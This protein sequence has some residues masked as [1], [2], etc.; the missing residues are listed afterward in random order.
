MD[1][2]KIE[3]GKVELRKVLINISA[4]TKEICRKWKGEAGRKKQDLAVSI[5]NSAIGIYLDPDKIDQILGNL[6][7]NAIRYTPEKGKIK[8]ELKNRKDNIELVI[9]DTGIGIAKDDMPKAF[10]KFQQFGRKPGPGAKGTGLGLAIVKELVELH[11]GSIKLESRLHKGTRFI[12]LFPKLGVEEVFREYIRNGIKEVSVK[13]GSLSLIIIRILNFAK[14]QKK[15]GFAGAHNLLT[16]IEKQAKDSLRRRADTLVRNTGD[17]MVLLFNTEKENVGIVKGRIEKAVNAYL[18][19]GK[20]K[21]LKDIRIAFG[22]AT[23]PAE[24]DTDEVLLEKARP[25]S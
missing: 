22:N 15:L 25:K 21:W 18:A 24:G 13:N 17:L 14:L 23:Y 11:K 3:A 1:I 2:S 10:D 19:E 16:D 12:L 6:L 5:P 20:E 7:S 4:T 9:S 8:V